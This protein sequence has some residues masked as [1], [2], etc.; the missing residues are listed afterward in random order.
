MMRK[1]RRS[2]SVA[3][4]DQPLLDRIHAIKADHPAWGYRRIWSCLR[5]RE[6][7]IL[8][9]NR[10]YRLLR[11]HH[12]LATQ[13]RLLRARRGPLRDKPRTTI[14]NRVWGTDMTKIHVQSW[15]WLY[16]HVVLDWGSKKVVGWH[17]STTS[18]TWD[19][20]TP[21]SS[22]INTQFPDGRDDQPQLLLV[23]DNGCQPTS[24]AFMAA[25]RALDIRQVFTTFNNPK[26]NADTER[27]F[28][29]LKEDL[30]WPRDWFSFQQ[31]HSALN[32][33]FH[34]Y[35]H[36]FPHSSIHHQT[37]AQYEAH[38]QTITITASP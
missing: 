21:L 2:A 7:M 22:A 37:P 11:E 18:K 24:T 17:L 26:G 29:T 34:S 12:L 8:G 30:V 19:W 35:N 10:V 6:G 13:T 25:C 14:P 28:R 1:R 36:D 20:L 38:H 3:L 27:I 23:S 4:R 9:K 32:H 31:L 33:W 15:G 5:Y 16:L